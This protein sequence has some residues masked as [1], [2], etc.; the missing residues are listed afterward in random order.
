MSIVGV[1]NANTACGW[2]LGHPYVVVAV[3]D[4]AARVGWAL[5]MVWVDVVVSKVG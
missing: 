4:D 2:D 5:W 3:D 1:A